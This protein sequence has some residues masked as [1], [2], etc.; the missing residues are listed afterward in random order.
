MR[1]S[2]LAHLLQV[3][4]LGGVVALAVAE[5]G[6]A[7]ND[8]GSDGE[9]GLDQGDRAE[10]VAVERAGLAGVLDVLVRRSQGVGE[11][12]EGGLA[13]VALVG[14]VGG[15]IAGVRAR[16][17][18]LAL[19]VGDVGAAVG[20]GAVLAAVEGGVLHVRSGVADRE[21]GLADVLRM[22]GSIE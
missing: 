10:R 18:E 1:P 20:G 12:G 5:R 16:G 8:A 13:S 21:G 3:Q 17:G 9:R 15:R 6:G 11:V 14:A 2:P 4:D 19:D 22:Q 7:V